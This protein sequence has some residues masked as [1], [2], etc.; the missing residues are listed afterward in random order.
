MNGK[1]KQ[2]INS[3]GLYIALAICI[4]AIICIGIYSAIIR[5]FTFTPNI[6]ETTPITENPKPDTQ[7]EVTPD[8]TTPTV[9]VPPATEPPETSVISPTDPPKIYCSP[10]DGEVIK[11]FS[12]DNLV[13]SLTMEDYRAHLGIDIS[14]EEGSAV[15]CFTDGTVEAIYKDPLMGYTIIVDHEEGLKSVYQNLSEETAENISETSKV[16]AGEILGYTANT[17]L[18]ECCENSHLHFEL[19]QDGQK[20]DPLAYIT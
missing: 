9:I 19:I 3:G 4:L 20:I 10:I 2:T 6:P 16:V 17:A 12:G 11:S 13:Y 15:R 1:K 8:K 5:M 7:P 14:C 18:I